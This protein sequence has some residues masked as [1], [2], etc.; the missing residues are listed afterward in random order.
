MLDREIAAYEAMEKP[1]GARPTVL[2]APSWQ[3]GNLLD[4]CAEDML[5]GL[6]GRGW[7]V[8]VRPHP[9]YTKRYRA[10]WEALQA[11]FADVG[12]DELYFERDFSSNSTIWSSDVLITDWSSVAC[13]FAFS[14]LKPCIFVDTPMKVSNPDWEELGIEPVDVTLRGLLGTSVLPENVGKVGEIVDA[15]LE[16]SERWRD[17]IA[18][19][20][21]KFVFNV[22]HGAEIAGQYILKTAME[23]QAQRE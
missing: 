10:R 15:L 2:V 9:E 20:R 16:Q 3:E 17:D 5:L 19:V 6:L 7:R 18:H 11:R 13:E 23:K 8:V 14:T 22:G 21:P 4:S 1:E 12:E